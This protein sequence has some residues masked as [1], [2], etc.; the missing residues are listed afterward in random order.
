[1]NILK[2]WLNKATQPTKTENEYKPKK[3]VCV[4]ASID[5]GQGMTFNEKAQHIFKQIKKK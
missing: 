4:M 1:M 5:E 3:F 2:D